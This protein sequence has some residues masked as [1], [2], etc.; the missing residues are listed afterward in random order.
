MVLMAGY[1]GKTAAS[2]EEMVKTLR[3]LIGELK[4]TNKL[5]TQIK[6]KLPPVKAP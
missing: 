5:L 1:D 3:T 4:Q 6:D 2:T